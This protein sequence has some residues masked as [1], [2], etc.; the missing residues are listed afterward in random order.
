MYLLFLIPSLLLSIAYDILGKKAIDKGDP[1]APFK[2]KIT[3][4]LLGALTILVLYLTDLIPSDRTPWV[5]VA[6]NPLI[7]ASALLAFFYSVFF[8]FAFK[9][10]G[11]ALN[12]AVASSS[13]VIAFI[14]SF[15]G[16]VII[17]SSAESI[18]GF[19]LPGRLIPV[20]V[21]IVG[22]IVL[23][24][25]KEGGSAEERTKLGVIFGLIA[26]FL[27][28]GDTV[29][30]V[31]I[32]EFNENLSPLEVIV[33][34]YFSALLFTIVSIIYVSIKDKKVFVPFVKANKTY[35]PYAVVFVI[36]SVVTT[37]SFSLDSIKSSLFW[38]LYPILPIIAARVFLKEH[39]SK[40]QKIYTAV[41]VLASIA[42]CFMDQFVY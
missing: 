39:L 14:I 36:Y 30:T 6:E 13:G 7:L 37:I 4:S 33:G 5:I 40:K 35:I 25:Y 17:G 21:M 19:F 32:Y 38:M 34:I 18:S 24:F 8:L 10:I 12:T 31:L 28:A 9:H 16:V 11:L 26:A 3:T 42:F 41:L 22:V 15:V 1:N 23:L 27:D 20:V 29:I 2:L